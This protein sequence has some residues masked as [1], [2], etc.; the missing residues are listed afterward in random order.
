MVHQ[1]IHRSFPRTTQCARSR[2]GDKRGA[3]RKCG[4][5][6]SDSL[7][8]VGVLFFGVAAT[9]PPDCT[10]THARAEERNASADGTRRHRT[11]KSGVWA[12]DS[13]AP[14]YSPS[15]ASHPCRGLPARSIHRI[16]RAF[17][18]F[19]QAIESNRPYLIFIAAITC[20]CL[21]SCASLSHHQFSEPAGGWQTK[22]GQ[23]M[24][25]TDKSTL[26]GEAIVRLS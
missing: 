16:A 1:R 4:Q 8:H 3:W 24:Y 19:V 17:R 26:I 15:R 11:M 20:F 14:A 5:Q 7:A 18:R 2:P 23:L 13:V 12:I 21:T 25:R 22:T 10:E 9:P 6:F